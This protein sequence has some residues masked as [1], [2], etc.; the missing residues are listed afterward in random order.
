MVNRKGGV[1]DMGTGVPDPYGVLR[2]GGPLAFYKSVWW[3]KKRWYILKRDRGECQ[4]CKADGVYSKGQCV[5]HIQH[6][7][8]R[9]DLALSDSNLITLC[10]SCHDKEH[11]EKLLKIQTFTNAEWF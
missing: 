6:L 3:A 10:N 1:L 4:R 11:P 7:K 5:H 9:P 8:H 2:P